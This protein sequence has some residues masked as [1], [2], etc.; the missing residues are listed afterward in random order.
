M[1]T[2]TLAQFKD[3]IEQHARD[4]NAARDELARKISDIIGD[5]GD[6]P[7]QPSSIA[8][9]LPRIDAVLDEFYRPDGKFQQITQTHADRG[10]RVA[11][12]LSNEILAERLFPDHPELYEEFKH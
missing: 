3:L 5:L 4:V 12:D 7:I 6:A 2:D 10:R 11:F 9:T 1:A 8:S